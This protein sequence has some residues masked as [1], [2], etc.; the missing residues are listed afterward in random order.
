LNARRD[1]AKRVRT[2]DVSDALRAPEC[3]GIRVASAVESSDPLWSSAVVRGPDSGRGKV[4]RVGQTVGDQQVVFIGFNP[5]ARS[6]AVWLASE[7]DLC[8]ALLFSKKT[9]DASGN[10]SPKKTQSEVRGRGKRAPG[11]PNSR[12]PPRVAKGIQRVGPR[13]YVIARSAVDAL[14]ENQS[15]LGRSVRVTQKKARTG[16]VLVLSRVRKGSLLSRIG[17]ERGDEI[18]A[19]N[20]FSLAS[21]E[22]ALQAFAYLRTARNLRL[23]LRR[24]EKPITIEYRIQ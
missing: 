9:A 14:L 22:K 5:V 7:A 20:G 24:G 17:L 12:L 1:E 18:E 19:L 21:P 13:E 16:T 10:K 11:R 23:R 15:L 3:E 4:R 2:L 6:P 8:Q